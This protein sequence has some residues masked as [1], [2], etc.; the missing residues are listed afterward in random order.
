MHHHAQVVLK[1]DIRHAMLRFS[2]LLL[3]KYELL[4][5]LKQPEI[6]S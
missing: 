1:S 3:L 5:L 2:S 4:L 6:F